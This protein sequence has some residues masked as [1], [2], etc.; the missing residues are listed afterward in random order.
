MKAGVVSV[1][2]AVPEHLSI[3]NAAFENLGVPGKAITVRREKDLED[4]D[5]LVIPGGES[6]TISRLL[7]RFDLFDRIVR[8]GREGVPIMGTCA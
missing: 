3:L 8:M 5:C 4:A 6:T 1:Q 7:V 2:G